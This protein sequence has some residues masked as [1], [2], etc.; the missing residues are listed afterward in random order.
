MVTNSFDVTDSTV[1]CQCWVLPIYRRT[2]SLGQ[3]LLFFQV[4]LNPMLLGSR[5]HRTVLFLGL[6]GSPVYTCNGYAHD[7]EARDGRVAQRRLQTP[8][9]L[10]P[11]S[12]PLEWGDINILHTTD[13]HGWLLGHQKSSFPEPN[14]RFASFNWVLYTLSMLISTREVATLENSRLLYRTWRRLRR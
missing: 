9:P 2:Y 12:R 1:T 4:L 11:P 8:A 10:T 6:C 3:P 5:L 7:S 13:T 14:Y